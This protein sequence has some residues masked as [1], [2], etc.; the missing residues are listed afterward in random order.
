LCWNE[1]EALIDSR[2]G[3]AFELLAP[4]TVD[5]SEL[6]YSPRP[7]ESVARTETRI[8]EADPIVSGS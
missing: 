3:G 8:K 5:R 4:K 1:G 6:A 2:Q 7:G